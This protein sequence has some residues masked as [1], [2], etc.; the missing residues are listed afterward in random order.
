MAKKRAELE[1]DRDE[2]D[3]LL[4]VANDAFASGDFSRGIS[5]ALRACDFVDSMMQFGRKYEDK[6]F[7]NIEVIDLLLEYCPL[8]MDKKSLATLDCL[9]KTQRRID[10]NSTVDIS[11]QLASA[12]ARM[13]DA[14]K[15][16]NELESAQKA[17]YLE[18]PSLIR[19]DSGGRRKILNSWGKL[20]LLT[21]RPGSGS[22]FV[23]L[24]TRMGESVSGKC[25]SCGVIGKAAKRKL[26]T[27]V[28]CPK[29]RAT[30][31]FVILDHEPVELHPRD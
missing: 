7:E 16:W 3:R 12:W 14:H 22:S 25:P 6:E 27:E 5:T 1:A 28:V 8:V 30:V 15:L 26:L 31:T 21:S 20:G 9:L 10:R 17:R 2:Y 24:A 11:R 13:W 18:L 23:K 4:A 29:C 19:G